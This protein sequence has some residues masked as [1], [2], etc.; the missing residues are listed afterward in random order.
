MLNQQ[1]IAS[2]RQIEARPR[3]EGELVAVPAPLT[4]AFLAAPVLLWAGMLIAG[5][6]LLGPAVLA[7]ALALQLLGLATLVMLAGNARA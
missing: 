1:S 3:T 5:T 6:V 7:A 2:P 4:V